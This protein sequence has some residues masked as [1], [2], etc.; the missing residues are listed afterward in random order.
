MTL[1]WIAG[2][3]LAALSV[4]LLV[5]PLIRSRPAPPPRG[6]YD[7][8]VLVDQL[9]EVDRDE[10]AGLIDAEAA[11]GA[12]R[13]VKRRLLAAMESVQALPASDPPARGAGR[14]WLAATLALAVPVLAGALYLGLGNPTVPDEPLIARQ[15]SGDLAEANRRPALDPSL[16]ETVAQLER[17]LAVHPGEG[18][19]WFLLGRSYLTIDR[20]ADAVT[21]L[22]KA[23]S[24]MPD[25]P[26]VTAAYGEALVIAADGHVDEPARAEFEQALAA[27]PRNVQ[28]RYYL[29]LGQAQ[30]KDVA[31]AL[32]SW[33]DLVALSPADAPWL[34]LVRQQIAAAAQAIGVDPATLKPSAAALALAPPATEAPAATPGP[35]AEDMKAAAQMSPEQQQA[36]IRSMVERLATRLQENP[37]DRQGWL[38]LAR[39]YDV[40]GETAK[41]ADARARAE[42]ATK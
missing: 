13:E 14:R 36:M 29:A 11:A 9:A 33:V 32:Q 10:A 1:L 28:A 35:S 19:G 20:T 22:A 18:Q 17:Y 39:A 34:P 24:L 6:S 30:Q 4:L 7:A 27:D 42:A 40:L 21:A 25:R 23:K 15:T 5:Q 38:R 41:A 8:A 3:L 26:D 16:V 2:G 12:R 31:G 37:D